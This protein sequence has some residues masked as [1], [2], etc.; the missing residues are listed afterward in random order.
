[1]ILDLNVAS[2]E[3]LPRTLDDFGKWLV[4]AHA[5]IE[6]W[7]FALIAGELEQQ[8]GPEHNAATA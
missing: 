6:S 4:N 8:L 1:V 5:I 2:S 3:Q 7:F